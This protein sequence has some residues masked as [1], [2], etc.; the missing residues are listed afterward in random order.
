[1]RP[2]AVPLILLTALWA[3]SCGSGS[4]GNAIYDFPDNGQTCEWEGDVLWCY[5]NPD[6]MPGFD[7]ASDAVREV[8]DE[9]VPAEVSKQDSA[10]SELLAE[11]MVPQETLQPPEDSAVEPDVSEVVPGGEFRGLW[12][13]R[14]DY[15][16]A[17][18]IA[19][20]VS[21][22]E[23]WGFNAIFFQVRGTADAYYH[24]AVE[25]WSAGLTGVLGQDP[26]WDPLQVALDEAHERGLELH[27]WV[28]TM[29]AWSGTTP[30]P[31]SDPPHILYLYP[32]WRMAD[33]AG[34]PMA[35][36]SSYTWVSPGVP[37]V[38]EH[39]E[40]VLMDL[41]ANYDVDGIHLDYI[42]Y[43]GPEYSHDPWSESAFD[44]AVATNPGLDWATFQQ[45]L[46]SAF[47][48]R[49]YGSVLEVRPSV[50]VTAAVWGIYENRF[51]WSGVSQGFWDYYQDSQRWVSE[52]LLDAIC[53]MI[54][55]P[56]TDPKGGKTDFA[57]LVDDFLSHA[58]NRHVYAGM[59]ADY[60]SAAELAAEISYV[61]S[62]SG[63]GTALFSYA[64]LM[65]KGFGPDLGAGVFALPAQPPSMLWK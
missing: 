9:G 41:A 16:N 11:D 27:A 15:S 42:R 55:W 32:S 63:P 38:R 49:L 60:A 46:L 57:T 12:V 31:Q 47:V 65:D 24:S 6:S 8:A 34:E 44:Q 30:P 53:P 10:V 58:G 14:W 17:Q 54:Y 62:V 37:G 1:M 64:V 52:G 18:D 20:L 35:W 36:N 25:P 28:N 4:S 40:S 61:R 22:A 50:K 5:A 23:E 33:A 48:A 29:V 45:D 21:R 2:S 51:G 59:K 3:A 26:G 56:M 43:A 39:I 19:T 7:D 13:S